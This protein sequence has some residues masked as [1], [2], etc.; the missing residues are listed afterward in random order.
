MGRLVFARS[1][2]ENVST[3]QRAGPE[4]IARYFQAYQRAD[5]G[6]VLPQGSFLGRPYARAGAT[7]A[8]GKGAARKAV[9]SPAQSRR[10]RV[11]KSSI[12]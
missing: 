9:E 12:E 10:G 11:P 3:R 8:A 7:H 2:A 6:A 5:E 1:W 4:F